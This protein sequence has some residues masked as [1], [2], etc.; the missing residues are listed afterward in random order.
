MNDP[1]FLLNLVESF[2]N[3]EGYEEALKQISIIESQHLLDEN[4]RLSVLLNMSN[5]YLNLGELDKAK[6]TS[7]Q[8]LNRSKKYHNALYE[9]DAICL[10]LKISSI[11]ETRDESKRLID[12]GETLLELLF[13]KGS[14]D[15]KRTKAAFLHFKATSLDPNVELD[16]QLT[17]IQESLSLREENNDNIGISE[18]LLG[19]GSY[20]S[21]KGDL[22]LALKLFNDSL[23]LREEIG[24]KHL[25]S[26][27][28]RAI[29][30]NYLFRG[31]FNLALDYTKKALSL[32]E[33]IKNKCDICHNLHHLAEIYYFK[34]E[35]EPAQRFLTRG[36][37]LAES[38]GYYVIVILG[39]YDLGR[40]F[41][42]RGD[43]Y[44]S[45]ECFEKALK[46]VKE[47]KVA[48][49]Q[50]EGLY[51]L[52][53]LYTYHLSPS[54]AVP[55]LKDLEKLKKHDDNKWH[56]L[57]F[58]ISKALIL[59]ASKRLPDK[60]AALGIF[61]EIV[62]EPCI[63]YKVTVE[64]IINLCELLLYELKTTGNED[65][66]EELDRFCCRLLEIANGQNSHSLLAETYWLQSK[67][68]L[69]KLDIQQAQRLLFK[70][71]AISEEK[72]LIMLA[73]SIGND[74]YSFFSQLKKWE[75]Y[76]DK[77]VSLNRRMELAQL[78]NLVVKMIHKQLSDVPTRT[79]DELMK[80]D[81]FRTYLKE[82]KKILL[83][84]EQK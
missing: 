76:I 51:H 26:Q 35:L 49:F 79:L 64:A 24:N 28:Y 69:L 48:F 55:L 32:A 54:K 1:K 80:I 57:M 31:K 23:A 19:L 43:F 8:L 61:Q 47:K 5:C 10:L 72:G 16:Q 67:L 33:S 81:D 17:L 50:A 83:Q 21:F 37:E 65:I 59:K 9:L 84:H 25:I 14:N 63:I 6:E 2:I 68:A 41:Q 36:I 52:I 66:F 75:E 82:A 4:T 78:E 11:L 62:E 71:Q 46:I 38:I 40:L 56:N 7:N 12:A 45:L 27:A 18:S 53:R 34:G 70:A 74:H 13:D 58:R 77:N 73:N 22:N 29:G 44:T 42:D 20:Y 60:M 30:N 15:Y 39:L 3:Q